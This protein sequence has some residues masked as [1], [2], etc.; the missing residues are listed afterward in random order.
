MFKKIIIN[1]RIRKYKSENI[2][3]IALLYAITIFLDKKIKDI[4]IISAKNL[5]YKIIEGHHKNIP[6]NKKEL[7]VDYYYEIIK[8]KLIQYKNNDFSFENDKI[9]ILNYL[10]HSKEKMQAIKKI[11]KSDNEISSEEKKFM[12]QIKEML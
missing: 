12:E 11:I 6:L 2:K 9:K 5:I 1:F 3:K 10:K 8:Q 7:V 4:E